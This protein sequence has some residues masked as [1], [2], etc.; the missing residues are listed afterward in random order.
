MR[1]GIDPVRG[2]RRRRASRVSRVGLNQ[3]PT[4][5]SQE[6]W[7]TARRSQRRRTFRNEYLI[8]GES[9]WF[10]RFILSRRRRQSSRQAVWR[11]SVIR[12]KLVRRVC[13]ITSAC[14]TYRPLGSEPRRSLPSTVGSRSREDSSTR[15]RGGRRCRDCRLH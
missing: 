10:F 4:G 9:R 11:T 13:V 3:Q 15:R 5:R 6:C 1:A 14:R 8:S 12:P 2:T 7:L